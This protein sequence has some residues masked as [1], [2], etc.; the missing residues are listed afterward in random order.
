VDLSPHHLIFGELN[1]IDAFNWAMK[2]DVAVKQLGYRFDRYEGS[3]EDFNKDFM[4]FFSDP[5]RFTY[6]PLIS[7]SGIKAA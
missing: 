3:F 4:A 1:K 6:T 2:A 7:C 5:R